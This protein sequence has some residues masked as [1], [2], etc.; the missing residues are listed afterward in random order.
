MKRDSPEYTTE[1]FF[2]TGTNIDFTE[3][4]TDQN[5]LEKE[6][7]GKAFPEKGPDVFQRALR[8]GQASILNL[9]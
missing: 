2:P 7:I 8:I 4:K 5:E 3:I 1:E 9:K 6:L